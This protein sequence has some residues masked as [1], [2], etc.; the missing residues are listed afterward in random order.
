MIAYI[1]GVLG[2]GTSTTI[3]VNVLPTKLEGKLDPS[4]DSFSAINNI[5]YYFELPKDQRVII[6]DA[7]VSTQKILT[8]CGICSMLIAGIFM[9]G[10]A[11][12]DLSVNK[13]EENEEAT[14][15]ANE[16]ATGDSASIDSQA[17]PQTRAV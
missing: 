13:K 8:I 15:L 4:V 3:W 7:Y 17:K 6:Q 10:L 5:T 12:Y 11:P 2:E 9:L 1:G 14:E 16:R